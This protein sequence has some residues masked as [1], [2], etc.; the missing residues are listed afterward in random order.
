V[1]GGL[2]IVAVVA[3]RDLVGVRLKPQAWSSFMKM[4]EVSGCA[5]EK[6]LRKKPEK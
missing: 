6:A 1:L 5:S 2:D 3:R 4:T